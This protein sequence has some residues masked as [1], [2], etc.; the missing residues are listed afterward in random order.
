MTRRLMILGLATWSA[1]AAVAHG[2]EP[3][4]SPRH[5]SVTGTTITRAQPDTVVWSVSVR[6]TNRELAKALAECDV[7]VKQVLTLRNDLMLQPEEVQTGY[8]SI[9]KIYDRDNHGNQTSFRHFQVIRSITLRQRDTTRFDEILAKLSATTDIE[10]SYQLEASNYHTLR[11]Q[12]R[13]GAVKA[14]REKAQ[15]MAELLGAKL[16]RV[17]SIAEPKET[18]GG[19]HL[20]SNMAMVSPRQAEPDAAPGTFAPG[21][22]EIRVSIDVVFEIE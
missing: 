18:W 13:L 20:G 5:V 2:D 19:A 1:L 12:T 4:L 10:V 21:A 8:L 22:I 15:A 17:L 7:T 3:K 6:R 9:Q 14:A 11:A 16:G